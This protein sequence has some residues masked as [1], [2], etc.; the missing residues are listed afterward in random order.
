MGN[1]VEQHLGRLSGGNGPI[2]IMISAAA[3]INTTSTRDCRIHAA[4]SGG[5]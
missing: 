1:A 4:F 3:Y 2:A 5:C